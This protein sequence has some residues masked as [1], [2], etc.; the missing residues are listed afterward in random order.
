M[1]SQKYCE[2]MRG[3]LAM[4]ILAGV[5][6]MLL[7]LFGRGAA[8]SQSSAEPTL[9]PAD[10][11]EYLRKT[12]DWYRGT[13]VEQ[14]I[15]REASDL[16]FL[17]DNH[18]ISDDIVRLAFEFARQQAQI[19]SMQGKT[20]DGKPAA[21]EP[22]QYQRL[23]QAVANADL[24]V[25]QS[26]KELESLR[27]KQATITGS[28]RRALD[29]LIAETQSELALRQARRDA[30][31]NML[32]FATG[33]AS[34]MGA[35]GLR[36]QIEELARSVP[37]ALSGTGEIP[38]QQSAKGQTSDTPSTLMERRRPAGIWGLA[39]DL[40]RLSSKAHTLEQQ[41]ES[42]EQLMEAARQVRAPL[43]ANL[44]QLIAAGD[45]LA[46][47]PPSN[48]PAVL[49]RQKEAVDALT[50][51]FKQASANLLPLSKQRILLD[52]YKRTLLNWRDSVRKESREEME[53]L[54]VRLA[55]LA[56]VIAAVFAAGEVWRKAIFRYIRETRRRYQFLLFRKVML[57]L[58][59]GIIVI[60]TFAAE[61]GSVATFAGLL[62][63]GV[64]V[65][66]Q[67]VI[68]SVAGYF[69]LMGKYGVRVGD[70]VQ[71]AGVTGEVV[72]IGLVR[73]HLLELTSGGPDA[74]P[75]GRVV[76]FSNSIVF[77]STSGVFKKIPGTS[78][79]W[80]E[81]SLTFSPET[82][83]RTIQERITKAVDAALKDDHEAMERQMR[84]MEQTL[85]SI[86][87]IELR[88]KT[89][90][91]FTTSGI[92]ATV[93]FPVETKNAMDMDDRV[94]RHIN[95]AIEEDPKLNLVASGGPSLKTD[96]RAST[97]G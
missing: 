35:A 71:I 74:Q 17:N 56:L 75:S 61:L 40:V 73:L 90:L 15:A 23:T 89:H 91:H 24:Q 32:Q 39:A 21:N 86:S 12:I 34:E 70:R 48:D 97:P 64:A 38:S 69:F 65:A 8:Y 20:A 83:Y 28:K 4:A 72:D 80:H 78:F 66:L 53:S 42:T 19:E 36:A 82:N 45:Q 3:M 51:Q 57:W 59:I 54:L 76:A 43:M 30:L 26:Q 77:Q 79:A 2:T 1:A 18:R 22:S 85:D 67:N 9:K 44:K 41:V 47:Q 33:T 37:A 46:G 13:V 52:L 16:T 88:P 84:H 62:T 68:L 25:D 14:Q 63:A 11:V 5:T 96:I 6:I 92:E 87:A 81:I 55:I 49:A 60:F 29:A 58:A 93:R 95:A 10:L 50:A 27:K 94:M 31:R 7:F